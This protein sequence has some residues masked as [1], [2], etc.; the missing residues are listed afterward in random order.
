[1]L[2]LRVLENVLQPSFVQKTTVLDMLEKIVGDSQI[3]IDIFVNFD[4]DADSPNIFERV[5][6]GLLKT[7]LGPSPDSTTTFSAVQDI[8]SRHESVKCLVGIIKSMGAWMDGHLKIV[9][10]ILHKSSEDDTSA[11][12]HST[13]T[14]ED[15][16]RPD[17]E[18]HLE[19]NSELSDAATLEQSRSHKMEP[20]KGISLFNRNTVMNERE[21]QDE[22]FRIE[23]RELG[24]MKEGLGIVKRGIGELGIL[25]PKAKTENN[26]LEMDTCIRV[27]IGQGTWA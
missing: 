24:E 3:I 17:C 21:E 22:E 19:M 2:I 1:M 15:G 8:T 4:C 16:T 10:S 13:L 6:N 14:A 7:S 18:L 27:R 5:V 20:Q 23:A 25:I 9:D 12:R 26:Y 11:E